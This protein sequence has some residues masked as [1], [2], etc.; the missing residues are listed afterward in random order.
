MVV[1]TNPRNPNARAPSVPVHYKHRREVDKF[2]ELPPALQERLPAC[3]RRDTRSRVPKARVTYDQKSGDVL[4]K[5][6]KARVGDIDLHL[7]MC[8]LDCRVSVNLEMDWDGSVEELERA[9]AERA[10]KERP[11]DRNKD[12][13]SYNHSHYQIDLTQVTQVGKVSF[14]HPSP[15][16]YLHPSHLSPSALLKR[17]GTSSS[18]MIAGADT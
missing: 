6:V 12:R 4:A 5:I 9:A 11:P 1:E 18:L 17:V 15:T 2:Y 13:L 3:M 8:P 10:D 16:P 7:P 14:I